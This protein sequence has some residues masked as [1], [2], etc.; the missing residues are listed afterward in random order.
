M[1][2]LGIT[3]V[4]VT[5]VLVGLGCSLPRSPILGGIYTNVSDGLLANPG[6]VGT[7]MGEATATGI[8]GVTLGD[9]SINAALAQ[10]QITEISYVDYY[11]WGILGVYAKTTTR[12]YG[13]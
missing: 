2:K 7:K 12:V 5:L 4:A 3:L 11:S 6:P 9:S 13:K 1:T 10:G 8:V